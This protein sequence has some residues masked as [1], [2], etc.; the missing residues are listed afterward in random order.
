MDTPQVQGTTPSEEHDSVGHVRL[1]IAG[2]TPNSLR[3][4]QS[5]REATSTMQGAAARLDIEVIDVFKGPKRAIADGILVTPTLVAQYSGR[6]V[7]MVG[8]LRDMAALRS[9][10]DACAGASEENGAPAGQAGSQAP[11]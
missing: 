8:D 5:L 4:Q 7:M 9:I 1:Y 11:I 2:A 10:L 3:A 6:R